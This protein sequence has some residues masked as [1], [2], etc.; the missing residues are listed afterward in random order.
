MVVLTN[1]A[2]V[3]TSTTGTGTITLGAAKNGYQTFAGSGVSDGDVVRYVI[4][5]G[6][7]FEIGTGTYTASGTTLTR[8]VTESSN[9]NSAIN[10]SGNNNVSVFI[11]VTKD[12][13]INASEVTNVAQ[14]KAFD[15]SD[16]A[17]AAQGT[18]ADNALP[19]AGGTMTGAITFAA[20]QAFDGRDVSADGTKLDGI[21]AGADVTDTANVTAAGALM[22][23]ELTNEAAVKAINQGLTTTSDVTF[24][25]VIVSGD[26]TVSGTTTS[27][28]TETVNI[29]DNQIV[30]N[31]NFTG[32]TP[33]ENGGIEIERGSLLAN[34]TLT[35]DEAND[36]WTVGSAPFVAGSFVGD[37][38]SVTNVAAASVN[39]TESADDN[40]LYNIL[41]SDTDG[42]GNV[43]MTPTQD[44]G[45]LV[46]NPSSNTLFV[47]NF[48]ASEI[49]TL[50]IESGNNSNTNI[51]LSNLF[52]KF[53]VNGETF[54]KL[55]EGSTDYVEVSKNLY[56]INNTKLVFE[57][58]TSD[59]FETTL[60]VVDP[61]ADR[62]ITLPDAT[63]TVA[64]DDVATTSDNGLMSSS[65]KTKLDGVESGATGDQTNAEIRAAVE[66]ATDSNVFTDADHS[67]LDGIEAGATGDQTNAEIRAAV[68]AATDSNV[69][70]DADHTKLNGIEAS[71]D[72]TD[73]T[74]VTAAGALMDSEVTNLAQVK[75]FDSSDYAT[76]AQGTTA[77]AA[78]ARSGGTMTGAITF[79]AGQSFDGRDVSADGSKL[80]G[81]ESGATGDQTNAEIRAAVEAATDSNVFTDADHTKLNGIEA[82][83]DVTDVTNVT[84][85]G[86]LM[87]SELTDIAS[88]K[89]LNQGVATTNSPTF[90][91]LTVDGHTLQDSTDRS[92]LLSLT[93]AL[94]T[95]RGI[96]IEPTTTSKWSVM[97][98][99]DDFGLYDDENNE[100]IIL[101]NENST[102]QLFSNGTNS[103]TV[104]TTG[105]TVTGNLSVTGTVDGRDVATDGTKLDGIESGATADQ[106]AAE[107][108]TAIKTVDGSGSGLDADTVDGIEA[109]QFLRS[110]AS[111]TMTGNLTVDNGGSTTLSV[112]C[113][114]GGNALVRAN[115]DNQGTGALEVG[116]SNSYGG[117][118]SYNGDG[119]PAWAGGETADNIT[120]YRLENGTR[121]EVFH[122][123]YN[124]DTVNFNGSITLGGTVDGRDVATD[125]T[126]LDGIEASADVTDT[127]NVTAAGALMDSEVTNLAQVKAFDSSDY[128][129]AAQGTT[130]DAALP[131]AGGTM[132]A[133]LEISTS[134]NEHL[135]L[136]GATDPYIRFQ[137]GTTDKAMIQW[138]DSGVLQFRN[139]ENGKYAFWP[140]V[141]AAAELVLLRN[142]T[143]TTSGEDLGSVNFGH[144]DGTPDF[145]TQTVPQLPARI[146]AQATE[147]TGTYDDGARLSFYTK[148][149]NANKDTNSIERV[150]IDQDGTSRFYGDIE[151]N[152]GG[153][154]GS[155]CLQ[156]N[157]SSSGTFNKAIEA[158]NSNLTSGESEQ[159]MMGSALSTKNVADW[160]FQYSSSG[161]DSNFMSFGFW[162]VDDIL[163]ITAGKVTTVDGTF[164]NNSD[165]RLKE[166]IKPIENALSDICQLEG[167]TFDWKESGT[168]GQGFIAQQVEPIIPDVVNTDEDTGMK[169]INYVGLIGHLVE[170]IKTQQTQ[171]DD[172]KAEIQ[173][174]KS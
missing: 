170:A 164:N 129:T 140:T 162:G 46:F 114:D 99:Q 147:S 165:E 138:S 54:I 84:A 32:P 127:A 107:I 90:A 48:S 160:R 30:L 80:D 142:D 1:R 159:F 113:D 136:S 91:A 163:K 50:S 59:D 135:I 31:S 111:D 53:A 150:R 115:G 161:S 158:L 15:S 18:T 144:T 104:Q 130:A 117:G 153:A 27:I 155:A 122:Y 116:Q 171:I 33:T 103:F 37:G 58:S 40:A 132:T 146:L 131:K 154:S 9:S 35:W 28:N 36:R 78:L 10:L 11:A 55:V 172:L 38:S 120:F 21:E 102:L 3:G 63:G 83:A 7:E 6:D 74:N 14:V 77:D 73:A 143:T 23:S 70:T 92:G 109:S 156:I 13:F 119:S 82:S 72:V 71:A 45:G 24:N 85:A 16:Y 60:Y 57:G 68:E 95:W 128:A 81:I 47:N 79:A 51:Q 65:D 17:T 12:D 94:G 125:G 75:A 22:D 67:K 100:W 4:E 106:T 139:Q 133:P 20:G 88:V 137:E 25:D 145:P 134:T 121:T 86:A 8:T 62:T 168:Q 42:S 98:D 141:T 112:K 105:A 118:I 110:D 26:L 149:T 89:A 49:E 169:S 174:M 19:K 2:K 173:S 123:P 69:F 5:D 126:K 29:A 157:N 93:T 44:D 56:L 108:L 76:A 101:Y 43:Q 39:V 166:N 124:S 151:I 152:S 167:V 96:Q 97:G 61:T 52:I 41:F 34:A 66:A 148:A 87:D 64:L